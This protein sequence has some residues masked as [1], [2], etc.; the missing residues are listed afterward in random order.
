MEEG[1]VTTRPRTR[2]FII[3][4]PRLT[5]ILDESEAR[6]LLL[7]APAGY[8]KTTLAREWLEGKEGVAWYSGGP[9]MADVAA[10]AAGIAE[11]LDPELADRVRLLAANG[12]PAEALAR[13]VASS[14]AAQ[15]CLI[16]AIDDCH[17]A[18]G[19]KEAIAFLSEL[20]PRTEFRV[21]AASRVRPAWVT[22]RMLVYGDATALDMNALAFT[23][24]ETDEI[25]GA[26]SSA[27]PALQAA[28]GWPAVIGLVARREETGA[29]ARSLEPSDLY[30]FLAEDLFNTASP[31]L[32]SSLFLLALGADATREVM[33]DVLGRNHDQLLAEAIELGFLTGA[34][35]ALLHPLVRSFLLNKLKEVVDSSRAVGSVTESLV[36]RSCWDECLAALE[37][38]P[39][40]GLIAA[41]LDQALTPLLSAGR[42]TTVQRWIAL[43]KTVGL[44][45][46]TVL[47]AEAEVALR[48]GD[49]RRAQVLGERAGGLIGSGDKSARA[50]VVAGRAA[51]L[52]DDASSA[53]ANCSKAETLANSME[54]KLDSLWIQFLSAAEEDPASAAAALGRMQRAN[55]ERPDHALRIHNA[56]A[57]LLLGVEGSP[58]AAADELSLAAELLAHVSDPILRTS[59]LSMRAHLL[60]VIAEYESALELA[61]QEISEAEKNGLEFAVDH[62]LL[63]LAGAL[64]RLRRFRGAQRRVMQLERRR[65]GQSDF[66]LRNTHLLAARLRIAMGDLYRAEIL[67]RHRAGTTRSPWFEQMAYRGLVLGALGQPQEAEA[68]LSNAQNGTHAL[69]ALA[70]ANLGFA[71]LDVRRGQLSSARGAVLRAIQTGCTDAVITA[72]RAFPELPRVAAK[73]PDLKEALTEVF[74]RSRDV[75]LGRRVGLTLPRELRKRETLTSR[76][77]EVYELLAQGRTNQEIAQTLFIS[78]STTKVHVRHIFEKLGVHSRAEAA[79]AA[80]DGH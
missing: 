67:L 33:R 51:H 30:E 60:V 68:C 40:P 39:Q 35:V 10:L 77:L 6:I 32:Q 2:S 36:Q 11:A 42:T 45:N 53:R 72:C 73:E 63:S 14:E 19:S 50:Y 26:S 16:L 17:H 70:I 78:N 27:Q 18:A 7:V 43:A 76:E 20:L 52:R 34:D 59:F 69:D 75:D 44:A 56:N 23:D 64:I 66:I 15:A 38:F 4:R 48:S 46:P 57:L 41:T 65:S 47:L 49:T 24:D 3:K 28:D 21:V 8:G 80:L 58:N 5:K 55:D 74:T 79:R 1:T 37:A 61:Q 25:V 62:G 12:Q 71:I 13:A 22:P 29:P 54:I 31:E 9:S